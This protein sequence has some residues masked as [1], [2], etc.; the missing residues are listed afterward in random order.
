M[1]F[2]SVQDLSQTISILVMELPQELLAPLA[3]SLCTPRTNADTRAIFAACFERYDCALKTADRTR[4]A[5]WLAEDFAAKHAWN[6]VKDEETYTATRRPDRETAIEK[7]IQLFTQLKPLKDQKGDEAIR[8]LQHWFDW[9]GELHGTWSLGVLLA[10]RSHLGD[11]N[12]P[13]VRPSK[14]DR[15][16]LEKDVR[17]GLPHSSYYEKPLLKAACRAD[18]PPTST[19]KRNFM[20]SSMR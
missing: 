8:T 15:A 7:G 11:L 1:P 9:H 4:A 20:P 2:P 16:A 19:S 14:T 18:M 12:L 5:R 6:L 10:I 17:R 13:F 3:T